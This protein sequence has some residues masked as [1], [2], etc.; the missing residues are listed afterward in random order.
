MPPRPPRPGEYLTAYFG[1]DR[2]VDPDDPDAY[3]NTEHLARHN[4]TPEEV[5]EILKGDFRVFRN[6]RDRAGDH[7]LIGRTVG[8]RRLLVAVRWHDEQDGVL[9]PHHGLRPLEGHTVSRSRQ[10]MAVP[11]TPA[12]SLHTA[13]DYRAYDEAL[14]TD[15]GQAGR[16]EEIAEPTPKRPAAV[17]LDLALEVALRQEADRRGTPWDQLARE[18][19]LEGLRRASAE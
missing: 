10:E 12:K 19:L 3:T 13:E 8:G 14:T 7:V 15:L 17:P 11:G 1:V 4:V 16:W 9:F 2:G 6:R 5:D 18:L